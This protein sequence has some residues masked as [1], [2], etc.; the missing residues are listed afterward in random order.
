[1]ADKNSAKALREQRAPIARAIHDLS[2]SGEAVDADGKYTEPWLKANADYD[3]LTRRIVA[4]EAVDVRAGQIDHDQRAPVGDPRVGRGDYHGPAEQNPDRVRSLALAGWLGAQTPEGPTSEQREA[5]TSLGLDA[6]RKNL[7]I[8]LL[9]T[10]DHRKLQSNFKRHHPSQAIQRGMDFRATMT[11]GT[12]G[13]GGYLTMPEQ[14]Q[15]SLEVNMLAFGGV[16]QVAETIRTTTG[17]PLS[18]PTADDTS[19]TG[20][21]VGET[22]D[23]SNSGAGGSDATFGLQTWYS[24]DFSSN[25]ILVP[26]GLLRDEVFGLPTLLGQMLGERL[27]RITNT[28]M[29]TGTGA[30]TITG[31]VTSATTFAAA[32]ATAIAYDDV[33][34]L[35]HSVDPA[36]RNMPGTGY[37]L[38]DSIWLALRLLK[39]GQGQYLWKSNEPAGM[40]DTLNSRPMTV[41]Q[42]M[43]STIASGTKTLLFGHL[44]SYKIR[45][46]GQI[47][48]VRLDER[49]AEY[50]R[51]AFVAFT[52]EDAKLMNTTTPRLKVLTH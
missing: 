30:A 33:I 18:W 17:E 14:L 29:T 15:T 7:T 51:V 35:E 9:D 16:R 49:Y 3:A 1:M 40:Q 5:M 41:N 50:R 52:S 26:L 47:Q 12:G 38:H 36:Y 32:S 42:D 44:P 31:I 46:V 8:K 37:M 13:T 48:L 19:N 28:R 45:T 2:D 23:V 43:A 4:I 21:Q 34:K 22:T 39:D 27:G 24:Y 10:D 25:M 20:S 11:S 6:N